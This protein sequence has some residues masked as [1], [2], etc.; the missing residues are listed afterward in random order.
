MHLIVSNAPI[1]EAVA[2]EQPPQTKKAESKKSSKKAGPSRS[3][4]LR[5]KPVV[6]DKAS[7]QKFNEK[8]ERRIQEL[9]AKEEAHREFHESKVEELVYER[10]QS[11]KNK[12][13][14]EN[15]ELRWALLRL[16][17]ENKYLEGNQVQ[18]VAVIDEMRSQLQ[19]LRY[20]L[21]YGATDQT[22]LANKPKR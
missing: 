5:R 21:G 4:S 13:M 17:E 22:L 20:E 16:T 9:E 2:T 19:E 6:E 11:L 7:E 14:D 3:Q 15:E 10:T 1:E 12:L 18:M 8:L